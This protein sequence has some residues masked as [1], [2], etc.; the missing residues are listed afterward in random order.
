MIVVVL[1]LVII[2]TIAVRMAVGADD[3]TSGC[4]LT[5]IPLHLLL[6]ASLPSSLLS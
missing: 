2:L 4:V 5:H 1:V 3:R 6:Q